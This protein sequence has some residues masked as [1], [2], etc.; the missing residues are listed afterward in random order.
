MLDPITE[1]YVDLLDLEGDV[2][3]GVAGALF[4]DAHDFRGTWDSEQRLSQSRL[5]DVST[6]EEPVAMMSPRIFGFD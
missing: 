4:A 2:A 3:L 1:L 5:E 6:A